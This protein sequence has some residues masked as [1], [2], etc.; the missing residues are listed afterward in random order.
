M[1]ESDAWFIVIKL[2]TGGKQRTIWRPG[3]WGGEVLLSGEFTVNTGKTIKCISVS[4]VGKNARR[5]VHF[6]CFFLKNISLYLG[7]APE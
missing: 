5:F 7:E 3:G 4:E 6:V 2:E 1:P